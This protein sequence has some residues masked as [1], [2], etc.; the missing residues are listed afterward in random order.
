MGTTGLVAQAFGAEE[1][2]EIKLIYVR[3]LFIANFLGVLLVTI[4]TPLGLL[5]FSLFEPSADIE[6]MAND[7]SGKAKDYDLK[8]RLSDPIVLNI[9]YMF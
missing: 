7:N 5:L 3:A 9:V 1:S 4:Q 8:K 6:K 2:K